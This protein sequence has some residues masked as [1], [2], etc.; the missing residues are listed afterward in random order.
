MK[1]TLADTAYEKLLD[2]IYSLKYQSGDRL[3]EQQLINELEI[4]RTPVREAIRRLA[5]DGLVDLST[6]TFARIHTF[7]A[8]EKQDIG[9]VRLAI[10][11]TVAPLI[12]LNASNRD[13]QDLMSVAADCQRASDRN[14]I[15]ERIRLD[16]EFHQVLVNLSGNQVFAD[17]QEQL[18]KKGRLIQIQHYSENGATFCNLAGHLDILQA[19]N[20]R[21][22]AACIKAMQDHLR[23]S[24]ASHGVDPKIW[25]VA[26]TA[27]RTTDVAPFI[28]PQ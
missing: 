21:N 4:S 8:K 18:T 17:L 24:Y 11:T 1:Q 10:D 7:T 28:Q 25:E 22:T 9:L 20:D 26:E 23:P 15:M 13:L 2:M 19:L 12:V 5:S 6:G 27:L 14:D 3:V 16:F